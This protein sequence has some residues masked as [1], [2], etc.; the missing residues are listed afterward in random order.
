MLSVID[1]VGSD[2]V[3]MLKILSFGGWT[4]LVFCV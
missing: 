2:G 1:P 3:L 4:D